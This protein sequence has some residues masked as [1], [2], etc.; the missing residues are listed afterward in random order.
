MPFEFQLL[1]KKSKNLRYD[2]LPFYFI[3]GA[4]F[5]GYFN[6]EEDDDDEVYWRLGILFLIL[7]HCL[8]YL[9]NHWSAR[10]RS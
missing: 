8:T 10:L 9:S 3:Y 5:Y 4:V 2:V 1:K 6:L 7:I